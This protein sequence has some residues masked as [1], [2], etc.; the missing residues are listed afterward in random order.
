MHAKPT[1]HRRF[2]RMPD[3]RHK[4][5]TR[6][7]AEHH[8]QH[9]VQHW[10]MPTRSSMLTLRNIAFL[11]AP[12]LFAVSQASA[13]SLS[14]DVKAKAERLVSPLTGNKD[15]RLQEVARF[16]QQVT[17]VTV[18]EDGRIFVN[19]PRWSVDVP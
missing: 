6:T 10:I 11:A 18:A 19:F 7:R 8:S 15:D 4:L 1:F 13:Q 9:S 16:D 17:G 3:S 12:L 14:Q 2:P 5:A